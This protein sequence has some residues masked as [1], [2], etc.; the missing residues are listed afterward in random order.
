VIKTVVDKFLV[1]L[2]SQLDEKKVF[3]DVDDE[4]R[5]GWQKWL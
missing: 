2:Q 3:L 1:Q 5:Y 4:A